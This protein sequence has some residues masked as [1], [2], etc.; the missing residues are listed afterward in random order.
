MN[1]VREGS[2]TDKV[3]ADP[4]SDD[5]RVWVLVVSA[6]GYNGVPLLTCKLLRKGESV[7]ARLACLHW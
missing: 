4:E 7:S 2:R 1:S 3:G 6:A 5:I